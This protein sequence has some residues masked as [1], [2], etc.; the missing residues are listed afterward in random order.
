MFS[1]S[2]PRL[3]IKRENITPK[4]KGIVHKH[5]KIFKQNFILKF[6]YNYLTSTST[7]LTLADFFFSSFLI[8]FCTELSCV[9]ISKTFAV[10]T[11][12]SRSPFVFL[13]LQN[14]SLIRILLR[15]CLRNVSHVRFIHNFCSQRVSYIFW[16]YNQFD[17]FCRINV[18]CDK[19]VYVLH[20]MYGFLMRDIQ[21]RKIYICNIFLTTILNV[22]V[23]FN[24]NNFMYVKWSSLHERKISKFIVIGNI[25]VKE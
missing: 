10:F 9:F 12:F 21:W 23:I 18:L 15:N 17:N 2:P 1:K 16:K 3:E 5:D 6:F 7:G 8:I 14:V 25:F 4:G 24:K 13:F 11:F 19:I 20:F 22:F